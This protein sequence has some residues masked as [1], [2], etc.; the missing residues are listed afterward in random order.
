MGDKAMSTTAPPQSTPVPRV[1]PLFEG[2]RLS[3]DE[4]ER[5]YHLMPN[6]V[7]AELIEGEVYM[8]SP[9][10]FK[11][12]GG[13]DFRLVAWAG[14]YQAATPGTDGGAN[15]TVRLDLTNEPQPDGILFIEPE[16]GG[17][18][19]ISEDDYI[20][21]APDLVIEIAASSVRRDK[22]PKMRAYARCGVREYIVWRTQDG[23]IEWFVLREGSYVPLASDGLGVIRSEIFP[24]L[25]L[26]VQAALRRDSAAI[27]DTLQQGLQS[28]EHA[29]F[30]AELQARR[31][32]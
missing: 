6:E 10:R 25:W 22:G 31:T 8:A 24:G 28:P 11:K 3:R 12:H 27:R 13:S 14:W 17:Q 32:S 19:R 15:C 29:R 23:V 30:V 9:E 4:F 26:N 7:K 18:V 20:E 5:R 2:D 16:F 1:L 21:N